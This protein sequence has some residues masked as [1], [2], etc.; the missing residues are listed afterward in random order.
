MPLR[1]LQVQGRGG[2]MREGG[3]LAEKAVKVKDRRAEEFS[4]GV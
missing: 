1:G 2:E 3:K 4:L